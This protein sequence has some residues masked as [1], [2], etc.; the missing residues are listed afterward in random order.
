MVILAR[1]GPSSNGSNGTHHRPRP[2]E[3]TIADEPEEAGPAQEAEYQRSLAEM[4]QAGEGHYPPLS[5]IEQIDHEALG[6][7][8][9]QTEFGDFLAGQL[10]RLAQ[11]VRWTGAATPAEHV[12]RMEVWDSEIR[13]QWF[14][15]GLTAAQGLQER[16]P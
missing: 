13:Q 3:W 2:K 14:D 5:L 15:Q 12:D 6:Y 4:E 8:S 7:R 16:R 9:M 11:L 1:N 10:E